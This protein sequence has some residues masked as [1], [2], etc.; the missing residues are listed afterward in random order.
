M[1]TWHAVYQIGDARDAEN[2]TP[3]LRSSV[4]PVGIPHEDGIDASWLLSRPNVAPWRLYAGSIV[5]WIVVTLVTPVTARTMRRTMR[6][7]CDRSPS[8]YYACSTWHAWR[9]YD[10]TATWSNERT[11]VRTTGQPIVLRWHPHPATR[12]PG[13]IR[14]YKIYDKI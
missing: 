2:G 9:A 1:T 11:N 8:A 4:S 13:R 12:P 5:S 7:K 3:A 10:R 14:L 6:R